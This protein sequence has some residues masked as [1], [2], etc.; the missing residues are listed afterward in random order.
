MLLSMLGENKSVR[1]E[2]MCALVKMASRRGVDKI[3]E[4]YKSNKAETVLGALLSGGGEYIT[5]ELLDLARLNYSALKNPGVTD[6]E[7]EKLRFDLSA[8]KNKA[9]DET[10]EF[11]EMILLEPYLSTAEQLF[12]KEK[13]NAY[14]YKSLEE[15]A[16]EALYYSNKAD[17]F[18]WEMFTGSRGGIINKI[19]KKKKSDYPKQLDTYAFYI[20]AKKLGSDDFYDMFFKSGLYKDIQKN[21]H[22]IFKEV[23]LKSEGSPPFSGRIARYFA[24]EM[25]DDSHINLA[26]D[27]VSPNDSG[28]L[29][30][31]SAY[32]KSNLKKN[33][34][35]YNIFEMLKKFGEFYHHSFKGL[36]ELYCQKYK[37]NSSETEY[38]RRYLI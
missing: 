34:Y 30:T 31:I 8:L 6:K 7:A 22:R 37:N 23:F 5:S 21:D 9:T 3:M 11:L 36:F 15:A 14:Y 35:Y 32:I 29:D 28:T 13:K 38:L 10:V 33:T 18:I 16:L 24:D 1:E 4:I 27:I 17:D 26:L 19:L 12:T 2:V 20:G 25:G